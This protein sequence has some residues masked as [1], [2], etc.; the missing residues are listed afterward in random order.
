MY[1]KQLV[2]LTVM[3][4]N[5]EISWVIINALLEAVRGG[6]LIILIILIS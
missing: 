4:L 3:I 5:K 6:A 1:I 2:M